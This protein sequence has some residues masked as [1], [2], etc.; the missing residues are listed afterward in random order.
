MRAFPL[1]IH[2]EPRSLKLHVPGHFVRPI[3]ESLIA[4]NFI[5]LMKYHIN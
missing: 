1:R 5:A 2:L 4:V 3:L